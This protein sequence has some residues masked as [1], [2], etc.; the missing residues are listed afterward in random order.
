MAALADDDL[1]TQFLWRSVQ[2]RLDAAAGDHAGAARLVG[3]ATELVDATDGLNQRAEVALAAAE[4]ASRAG[5]AD[6]ALTHTERATRLYR[7]K[8]NL[9]ALRMLGVR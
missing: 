9:A 2:A 3:E 4:V 1:P 6:E 5:D 8:A 7:R